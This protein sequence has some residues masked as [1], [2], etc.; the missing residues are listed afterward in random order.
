M[1]SPYADYEKSGYKTLLNLAKTLCRLVNQWQPIIAA[2]Y[3]DNIAMMALLTA[4]VGLCELIP[5][6]DSEFKAANL[7]T[8]PPAENVEDIA[9]FDPSA[10]P[11]EDP[12]LP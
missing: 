10:P 6:A 4:V 12:E 7:V 11:A 8:T 3:G 2:K 1:T 9:G 5:A